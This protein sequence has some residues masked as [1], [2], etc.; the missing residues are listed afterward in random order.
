MTYKLL[1]QVNTPAQLKELSIEELKRLAEEIRH[2]LLHSVSKTG[3]HLSSNL[4]TVELTLAMHYVFDSPH[5]RI[6]FDV[7]HQAYTHKLLTGRREGF[8]NLRQ[9]DGMSGF[10]KREE[11]E[12]D[13]FGAGH[14]S[15][16]LSAAFGFSFAD[17]RLGKT[18][19]T[20]ALIGDGSLTGGMAYE[21]LNLIGDLQ[22]RVIIVINDNE[23]SIS[24][25]VG[26]LNQNLNTLRTYRSYTGLKR[27]LQKKVGQGTREV[28]AHVKSAMRHLV[29]PTSIFE[30]LGIKYYGPVDGHDVEKLITFFRRL[31]EFS[32]PVVLH[33]V[34]TKGKGYLLAEDEP[35]T[36]HGVS[37]FEPKQG[38]KLNT[39]ADFSSFFGESLLALATKDP[40][41]IAITA[42]MPSGTGLSQFAQAL[43][44]QFLDV[45]IAEEH[46]VTMASALALAGL[47]PYVAIYSTF[48][49]R[50][51]DQMIH[52]VALQNSEVVFCIDRSGLV[53]AD[54]ETHQGI[55]D[56]GYLSLIPGMSVF[57]PKD[58]YE[59]NRILEASRNFKGPL[60]IKYPRETLYHINEDDTELLLPERIQRGG[61]ILLIGY[62]RMV[63]ILHEVA[64]QL[65]FAVDILNHRLIFPLNEPYLKDVFKDYKQ[66][67]V[68]EEQALHGS[69]AEKIKFLFPQVHIHTLPQEF[70]KQGSIQVL[71]ERYGLGVQAITDLLK[72]HETTY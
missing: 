13:Q 35:E 26:A 51:V 19:H 22:Q 46:A 42:A 47:K 14:A 20:I 31:K 33:A 28:L 23:M 52:D 69:M 11:S 44:A 54:G 67:Y 34:T 30:D 29:L 64:E 25:N 24:K 60:A 6:I 9:T 68:F 1:E 17:Q 53:G 49:Q 41:I 61:S 27:F 45:G 71:L 66:I 3:G 8:S 18:S 15:T 48:L 5:D 55:Y 70:I 36:Y 56:L 39:K 10:L 12:H 21:A 16:S 72:R 65:P 2:F 62:G 57:A 43:P 59:F 63:K 40:R 37:A 4:G 32:G 50:A 58:D 38:M 7:G